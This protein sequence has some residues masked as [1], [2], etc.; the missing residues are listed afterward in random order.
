[1]NCQLA[2]NRIAQCQCE[3]SDGSGIIDLT[4]VGVQGGTPRWSDIVGADQQKYS[5]NPCYP[6]V[7]ETCQDN[8]A[9]CQIWGAGVISY[10]V[11]GKQDTETFVIEDGTVTIKYTGIPSSFK[12]KVKLICDESSEEDKLIANGE[13]T[14]TTTINFD[15]RSLHACPKAPPQPFPDFWFIFTV[16]GIV[17]CFILIVLVVWYLLHQN[18]G[19]KKFRPDYSKDSKPIALKT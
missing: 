7:E 15:L 14:Q 5:Y 19:Y 10:F 16:V 17:L 9:A 2:C 4:Q 13:E 3:M 11:Y 6:F 8:V 1:M 18:N 12:T